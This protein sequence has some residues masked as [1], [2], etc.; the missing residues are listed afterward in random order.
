MAQN[1]DDVDFTT[2]LNDNVV[3]EDAALLGQKTYMVEW[4]N[5]NIYVRKQ[6]RRLYHH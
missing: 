6:I 2:Y 3:N 4:I 5:E 1:N